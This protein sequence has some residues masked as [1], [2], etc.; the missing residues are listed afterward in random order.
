MRANHRVLSWS[1]PSIVFA[2]ALGACSV[3][4]RVVSGA[5]PPGGVP[6][7]DSY[8]VLGDSSGQGTG[9][10]FLFLSG[11]QFDAGHLATDGTEPLVRPHWLGVG[12]VD[13]VVDYVFGAEH[14]I[15]TARRGALFDALSEFPEADALLFPRYEIEVCEL[16]FIPG[17][18]SEVTVT[19][20]G[21][22]V[23][24]KRPAAGVA[25]P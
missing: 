15:E 8:E 23:S 25:L 9:L 16:W 6:P 17:V 24:W 3:S 12:P 11:G 13:A 4:Y 20:T 14:L 21:T 22:A 2:A 5:I 7:L 10:K 18:A 19:V 1:L